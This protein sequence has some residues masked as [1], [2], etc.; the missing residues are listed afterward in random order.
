MSRLSGRSGVLTRVVARAD[1]ATARSQCW[2]VICY[3]LESV[4]QSYRS[5][6]L[7]SLDFK[8]LQTR[9][10]RDALHYHCV[11]LLRVK[12]LDNSDMSRRYM[13]WMVSS[14]NGPAVPFCQYC[15]IR[16]LFIIVAVCKSAISFI[17][18][19]CTKTVLRL[20]H[21]QHR[22]RSLSTLQLVGSPTNHRIRSPTSTK[23]FTR[24][25]EAR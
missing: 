2:A 3:V 4:A 13:Q 14:G 1:W 22:R 10:M 25:Y 19:R 21:Q 17:L 12:Q 24:V 16:T 15:G 9:S 18:T 8:P 11:D 23:C 6:S 5:T 20:V 7:L